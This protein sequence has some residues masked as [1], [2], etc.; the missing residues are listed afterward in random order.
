MTNEEKRI[1]IAEA[2]GWTAT[3][4]GDQFWRA[5]RAD[6]SYT[7]ELWC[8]QD[9]VWSAGIPDYFSDL[10]ACNDIENGLTDKQHQC[11]R[12]NLAGIC[13]FDY[14]SPEKSDANH[15]RKYAS[16]PAPQRAEAFGK[17]MNLW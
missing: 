5:T 8:S 15:H 2:C 9:N 10:N 12:N 11:F 6:G 16:A 14:V 4:D 1:K 17:T 7:S 13:G 3:V